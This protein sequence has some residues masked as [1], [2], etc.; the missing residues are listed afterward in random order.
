MRSS[1]PQPV[2]SPSQLFSHFTEE[3]TEALRGSL[4]CPELHSRSG[5]GV[6]GTVWPLYH[7]GVRSLRSV[8]E[9]HSGFGRVVICFSII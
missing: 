9:G 1:S 2:P 8:L 5:A 6:G 4:M 3:N 7:G